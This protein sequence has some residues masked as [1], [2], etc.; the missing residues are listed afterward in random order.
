[1]DVPDFIRGK[2][3]THLL[4]ECRPAFCFQ[5]VRNRMWRYA[6][7][8]CFIDYLDKIEK[9]QPGNLRRNLPPMEGFR[10]QKEVCYDYKS[11]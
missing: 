4:N 1:M 7:I 11:Q 9:V 3:N 10:P 2:Y 8:A 6:M 5:I